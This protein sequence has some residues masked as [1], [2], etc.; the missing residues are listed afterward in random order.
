MRARILTRWVRQPTGEWDLALSPLLSRGAGSVD[1]TGQPCLS[2]T[3]PLP[4]LVTVECD[5]DAAAVNRVVA[6]PDHGA[7][8]ILLTE[9]NAGLVPSDAAFQRVRA[10]LAARGLTLTDL[11]AAVG[12]ALN[13]RTR[14]QLERAAA[15]WLRTR[16]KAPLML[17]VKD[18]PDKHG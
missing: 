6:D 17:G 14:A 9:A 11:T 15:A 12:D 2:E 16:P 10:W 18:D 3:P 7:D 13:G 4:N 1:V 5:V 8:S